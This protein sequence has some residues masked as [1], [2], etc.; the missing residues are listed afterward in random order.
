MSWIYS[1][2]GNDTVNIK[3]KKNGSVPMFA[4]K[5]LLKQAGWSV[6]SSSDGT[7]YNASGDQIT[8]NSSGAGGMDNNYAWF[9]IQDPGALR[10][11]VFQRGTLNY[12][13]KWIYSASDKFTGGTP[14]ATT[15]PTATDEQGLAIA[16]TSFQ[17]LFQ[18]T[19]AT[20]YHIVAQDAPHN[21]VYSWWLVGATPM[22]NPPEQTI[23]ICEAI[24]EDYSTND[25]DPCI[26]LGSDDTAAYSTL[27]GTALST[28]GDAFRCWMRYGEVDEEWSGISA[29]FYYAT[30]LAMIPVNGLAS[31]YTKKYPFLPIFWW[32]HS[33]TGSITGFKG[34]GKYLSWRVN[35]T[36]FYPLLFVDG[37]QTRLIWGDLALP[38]FPSDVTPLL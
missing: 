11:Y 20:Y 13:W 29:S 38:G 23:M 24:N 18:S 7:T 17:S 6:I 16:T 30:A 5:E 31:P 12:S 9:R 25:N 22:S 33:T 34:A 10:E 28:N 27:C 1:Y 35:D 3:K 4:L 15:I 14:D 19:I 2:S 26:H 8:H 32:R 21:G 36:Q 37:V